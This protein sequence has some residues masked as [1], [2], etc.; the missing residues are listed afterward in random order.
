MNR[1]IIRGDSYGIR[2]PLY[3]ITIFDDELM[4]PFNLSGCTVR[5]TYK[6]AKTTPQEDP[7]DET[8]PI[9]HTLVVDGSGTATT[10]NGIY[11]VGEAEA[12]IIEERL[13][14]A[15]SRTLPLDIP[16]F[17]DL[18]I[19]DSNNEI[20]TFIQDGTLVAIDGYTNREV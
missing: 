16:L 18:E 20:F 9:K 5:T 3:R 2:R 19:T 15:E 11:L 7:T 13:T 14:A 17:S 12:G 8:A 10:Q 6:P 1:I 4:E